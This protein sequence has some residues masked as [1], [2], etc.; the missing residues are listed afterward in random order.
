MQNTRPDPTCY[1][2]E[3]KSYQSRSTNQ[4][5]VWKVGQAR[6]CG[7]EHREYFLDRVNVAQNRPINSNVKEMQWRFHKFN[8][9][10]TTNAGKIVKT[11]GFTELQLH[12]KNN[13]QP[14]VAAKLE[15][16]PTGNEVVVYKSLGMSKQ[17]YAAK[18]E[19]YRKSGGKASLD[20]KKIVKEQ[21]IETW[22]LE[23]ASTLLPGLVE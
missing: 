22:F 5:K 16:F 8:A 23:N 15:K 18:K 6:G 17:A 13:Q 21:D 10:R 7:P 2:V 1:V 4:F 9:T 14:S 3:L 12:T 11:K 19:Q 20:A